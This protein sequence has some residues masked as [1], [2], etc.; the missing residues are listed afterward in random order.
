MD[1]A[2]PGNHLY[3]ARDRGKGDVRQARH[4]DLHARARAARQPGDERDAPGVGLDSLDSAGEANVGEQ[5]IARI[6]MA[7]TVAVVECAN[8]H[9]A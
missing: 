8:G 5:G 3:P 1:P 2:R 4:V 9:R 6:V 7:V